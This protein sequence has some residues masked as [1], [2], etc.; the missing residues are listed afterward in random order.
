MRLNPAGEVDYA[1]Y[2]G[3]NGDDRA[4]GIA[5]DGQGNMYVLGSTTATD[6]PT[7]PNA[8]QPNCRTATP[9]DLCYYDMFIAKLASDG[10]QLAYST[11]L[12]SSDLSGLDY[13]STI[14]VDS[15]GNATVAGFTAS[16]RWPVKNA[17]QSALNAAPCPNAFQDR[18]CFDSVVATFTPDGQ[19]AF[20]SYLGGKFDEYSNDVVLGAD[21]SIYLTGTTESQDFPSTAGVVQ[22]KARSG[23]DMFIAHITTADTSTTSPNPVP[24]NQ[25]IY[26]PLM[27]R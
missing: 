11:Y 1:T 12:A 2:L 24:G 13:P 7:T 27:R 4:V 5:V 26:L 15:N 3:G 20:S 10:S 23:T 6:F 25:R 8:L 22:P 19:L 21:G 9:D 17:F 18:L 14:A 16:E